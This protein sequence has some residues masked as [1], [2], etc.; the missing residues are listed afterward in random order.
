MNNVWRKKM[1]MTCGY[2][3]PTA[4]VVGL[5]TPKNSRVHRRWKRQAARAERRE[6]EVK[7]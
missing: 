2:K 1:W 5:G 6:V 4:D 3:F 7:A